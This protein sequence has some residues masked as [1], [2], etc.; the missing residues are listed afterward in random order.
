MALALIALGSNLQQPQVQVA[1]AIQVLSQTPGLSLVKASSL[2]ATAPIGYDNQ[3]DFI[4]AVV[5]VA[6]DI[7]APELMELL[8]KIEQAFGRERP[9]PNAPRILD[10][11][12][13]DYASMRMHTSHLTLPHPRMHERGFVIL[14]LAEIVPDFVLPQGQTVVEW[15]TEFPHDDVRK[16]DL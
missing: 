10:L 15:A 9:F 4:N 12:L 6:T 14:P 16:L 8:L 2:Y 7:P 3:P 11:D 5:Q 13:L 1:N